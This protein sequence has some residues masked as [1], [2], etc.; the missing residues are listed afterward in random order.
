M[1]SS[2]RSAYVIGSMMDLRRYRL[3]DDGD[4]EENFSPVTTTTICSDEPSDVEIFRQE[5][6][7]LDDV[8]ITGSFQP[9]LEAISEEN[10]EDL[11]EVMDMGHLELDGSTVALYGSPQQWKSK[12]RSL[13]PLTSCTFQEQGKS[14]G[15]VSI[16]MKEMTH[17]GHYL[18][19]ASNNETSLGDISSIEIVKNSFL[20]RLSLL[21]KHRTLSDISDINYS[22][23]GITDIALSRTEIYQDTVGDTKRTESK[24]LECRGSQLAANTEMHLC[25]SEI[26]KTGAADLHINDFENEAG[27]LIK[28]KN[29]QNTTPSVPYDV[30]NEEVSDPEQEMCTLTLDIL[31]D[32]R[33]DVR[34][35]TCVASL[36]NFEM[37]DENRS[38]PIEDQNENLIMSRKELKSN[39]KDS[40]S[41]K[42]KFSDVD[43]RSQDTSSN[44]ELSDTI[45]KRHYQPANQSNSGD[46]NEGETLPESNKLDGEEKINQQDDIDLIMDCRT[47]CLS[48]KKFEDHPMSPTQST[49]SAKETSSSQIILSDQKS[50][51]ESDDDRNSVAHNSHSESTNSEET[52]ESI[53]RSSAVAGG[54]NILVAKY[55]DETDHLSGKLPEKVSSTE[56]ISGDIVD[57]CPKEAFTFDRVN[58]VQHYHNNI[59]PEQSAHKSTQSCQ[60]ECDENS[61]DYDFNDEIKLEIHNDIDL[62]EES[63]VEEILHCEKDYLESVEFDYD[64]ASNNSSFINISWSQ[65]D[66][67]TKK[68]AEKDTC[69]TQ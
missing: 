23:S 50:D 40:E 29:I 25:S 33:S 69:F 39:E 59:S 38:G 10:L 68:K 48:P 28:A 2:Q 3:L 43:N 58:T 13:S 22:P 36:C 11:H 56:S 32:D 27:N 41:M 63:S 65:T 47:N 42:R 1:S 61:L 64:S 34:E 24:Q 12:S 67:I 49:P 17:N 54:N 4:F 52:R 46:C 62:D 51:S 14:I 21:A 55:S 19:E 7:F 66:N 60:L 5:V 6:N 35:E 18:E 57:C 20:N 37:N 15:T 8:H 26:L 45:N 31:E 16:E 44:P 9:V 53:A 30:I